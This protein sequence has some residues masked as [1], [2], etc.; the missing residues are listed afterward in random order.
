MYKL[1]CDPFLC[2]IIIGT[3]SPLRIIQQQ[4]FALP[5]CL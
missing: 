1:L 4:S 2:I 3:N 5:P